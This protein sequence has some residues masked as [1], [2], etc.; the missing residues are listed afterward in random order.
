M[1]FH[2]RY[3]MFPACLSAATLLLA[4]IAHGVDIDSV[5]PAFGTVGQIITITGTDF[6]EKKPKV[7]LSQPGEK[8]TVKL[9]VL[10]NDPTRVVAELKKAKATGFY[11]V[12]VE[13]KGRDGSIDTWIDGFEIKGIEISDLSPNGDPDPLEPGTAFVIQ[14]DYFGEKKGK[15]SVGPNDGSKP[16]KAKVLDWDGDTNRA[17]IAVPKKVTDGPQNVT[18][19]TKLGSVTLVDA[20]ITEAPETG[21]GGG[22]GGTDCNKNNKM[23]AALEGSAVGGQKLF[24]SNAIFWE[25]GFGNQILIQ[26]CRAPDIACEQA[27][28]INAF[29]NPDAQGERTLDCIGGAIGMDYSEYDPVMGPG[30]YLEAGFGSGGSCSVTIDV[31]GN[32]VSGTF[33]ATLVSPSDPNDTAEV[34]GCFNTNN[35]QSSGL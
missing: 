25:T 8:K 23:K 1:R 35:R 31:D 12:N 7:F 2:S 4:G 27:L 5:D 6:G 21:G 33:T 3:L 26:G 24:D 30:I 14:G 13:T 20:I 34:I 16:K 18:V 32:K 17:T 19:E 28:V 29:T 10:E 15:V 9:K 11:D 22:G